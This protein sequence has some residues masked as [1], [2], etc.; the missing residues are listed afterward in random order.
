MRTRAICERQKL[1]T[2]VCAWPEVAWLSY[3]EAASIEDTGCEAVSE[4]RYCRPFISARTLVTSWPCSRKPWGEM[5]RQLFWQIC[6]YIKCP[7]QHARQPPASRNSCRRMTC[8]CHV[9][10]RVG[11]AASVSCGLGSSAMRSAAQYMSYR[12]GA[13]RPK[14][15]PE[16]EKGRAHGVQGRGRRLN[17]WK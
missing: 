2:P 7:A 17:R 1:M 10:H 12:L 14:V 9:C 4:N 11:W 3:I 13:E 5:A 16:A 6:A 15:A 8:C